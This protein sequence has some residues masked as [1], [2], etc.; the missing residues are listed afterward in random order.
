MPAE[1]TCPECLE[2]IEIQDIDPAADVAVCRACELAHPFAELEYA[3]GPMPVDRDRLPRG[4]R[5]VSDPVDL[6]VVHRR[7]SPRA[8]GLVPFTLVWICFGGWGCR[9]RLAADPSMP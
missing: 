1:W 3:L 9:S 7:V 6:R 2:P 5:I 4:V 8:A